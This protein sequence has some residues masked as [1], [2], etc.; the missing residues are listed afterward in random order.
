DKL[1]ACI[2]CAEELKMGNQEFKTALETNLSSLDEMN[3]PEADIFIK[4]FFESY[5]LP[6]DELK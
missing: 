2:K 1:S 4:E 3:C 5:S 6:L